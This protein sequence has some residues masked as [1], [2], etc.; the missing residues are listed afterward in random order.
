M[1]IKV[2]SEKGH[3]TYSGTNLLTADF[4]QGTVM[5]RRKRHNSI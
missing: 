4:L 5:D 3:I 2:A 1:K